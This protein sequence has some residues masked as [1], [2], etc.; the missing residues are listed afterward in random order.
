MAGLAREVWVAGSATVVLFVLSYADLLAARYLLSD[1]GSANY[2]VLNVLTKGAI[3][4]PQVITIMA[5]PYFAKAVRR[6]RRIAV[7]SVS[8]IGAILVA[9]TVLFGPLALRLVGGQAYTHLSGYAPA[10]AA[11]GALYAIVFVLTNAQVA[12]G[13]RKPSA[14]LWVAA[15]LFTVTVL[16]VRPGMDGIITLGLVAAAASVAALATAVALFDNG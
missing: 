12:K 9:A 3:W 1:Q 11:L 10:F 4:A 5:L 6:S 13:G 2:A 16:V 7:L 14:P 15:G 8:G